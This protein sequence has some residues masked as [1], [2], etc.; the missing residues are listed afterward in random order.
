MVVY[1]VVTES[2]GKNAL[3]LE[4]LMR[5]LH[6]NVMSKKVKNVETLH[7]HNVNY[8]YIYHQ[9]YKLTVNIES[10]TVDILR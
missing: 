3:P 9:Q 2:V 5:H 4:Q 8:M 10:W 6:I 1:A 7:L